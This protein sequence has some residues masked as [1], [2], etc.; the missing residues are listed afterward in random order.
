MFKKLIVG[1]CLLGLASNASAALSL[2][3]IAFT[4]YN[5]DGD[6]DFAF[7]AL[8]TITSETIFFTDNESDGLG[9]IN[10]GEGGLQ[11]DSGAVPIL[12]GTIVFFTDTDS[13]ANPGFA[14]SIGTL[15][16][17]DAGMNLAGG[18]D[19]ILAFQGVDV[20]T[21]G[22]FLAGIE[23]AAAASGPLAGTGLTAGN[24]FLNYSAGSSD[25]GGEYTGARSGEAAF[26]NYLPLVNNPAN[27]TTEATDG[28]LLLPHSTAAFTIGAAV[29][30]PS[31]FSLLALGLMGMAFKRKKK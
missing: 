6:D 23:N 8:A 25:D 27:W 1:I 14:A 19:S 20:F 12:A 7:V 29:P 13:V 3:D 17:P 11:W 28:E 21:P 9:G 15:T 4:A 22:T 30:E 16:M 5:A 31:T 10:T 18:G 2:G 26:A 24:T